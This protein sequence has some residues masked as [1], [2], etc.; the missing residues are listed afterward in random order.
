MSRRHHGLDLDVALE[1]TSERSGYCGPQGDALLRCQFADLF[2][3]E[4]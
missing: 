1:A 4:Q 3:V 2:D